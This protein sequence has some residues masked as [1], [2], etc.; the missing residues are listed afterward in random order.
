VAEATE[1][2][3][4]VK[5]LFKNAAVLI[6]DGQQKLL[7]VGESSS[8]VSLISASS[9]S[10]IIEYKGEHKTVYL[11][12]SIGTDFKTA[13][14]QEVRLSSQHNGHFYGTLYIN[15]KRGHF[16]VDTGAS[17]VAMSSN[18]AK[19]L[20]IDFQRGTPISVSTASGIAGGFRVTLK[21]VEVGSIAVSNVEAVVLEGGHPLDILLG[22]SFLSK[23][24]MRIDNG[25]LLLQ[26]KY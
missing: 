12:Q 7:K 25:V 10:A 5:G 16:L 21:R 9:K 15:G 4:R 26:S 3:V 11:S 13:T 22:N 24:E 23:V 6:I 19:Q 17:S 14:K 18:T 8:G 1:P 2:D 20:G